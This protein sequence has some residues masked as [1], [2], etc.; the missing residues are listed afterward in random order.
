MSGILHEASELGVEAAS[1]RVNT[2]CSQERGERP[3]QKTDGLR[4]ARPDL[5]VMLDGVRDGHEGTLVRSPHLDD[6]AIDPTYFSQCRFVNV[7]EI[8]HHA[9]ERT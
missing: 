7:R 9:P 2:A 5:E 3:S 6:G 4:I 1:F 8:F